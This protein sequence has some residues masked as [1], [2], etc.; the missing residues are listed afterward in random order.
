M[1]TLL[2]S[3]SLSTLLLLAACE[4]PDKCCD[5]DH[6]HSKTTAASQHE[7][8]DA[9]VNIETQ[10]AFN[11]TVLASKKPVVVDFTAAWC[12]ACQVFKPVFHELAGEL[13]DSHTFVTIDIDKAET[14][15]K[16][17]GITG[18]P[19]VLFFKDGNELKDARHPSSMTKNELKEKIKKAFGE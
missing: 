2:K 1:K 17:F 4:C 14:I 13:K 8:T 12:G 11:T 5:H 9:V 19:T 16:E 7:H 10:E 6:G 18:I 15:A 3:L